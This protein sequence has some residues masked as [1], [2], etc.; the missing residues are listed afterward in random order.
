[1][2]E[3]AQG[4]GQGNPASP[5]AKTVAPRQTLRA[6]I[7]SVAV[8]IVIACGL[9]L[10]Y[11]RGEALRNAEERATSVA[12]LLEEHIT[13]TFRT[14]DFIVEQVAVLG[15]SQPIDQL[16]ASEAAWMRLT[17]LKRG[18]P[19]PGTLWIIDKDGNTSLGTLTFPVRSVS[20]KDRYYFSAHTEKRHDLVIGP[21]VTAKQR[22]AQAFHLSRRIDDADGNLAGVAAAGFDAITFTDFYR[23]LG[24]GPHSVLTVAGTD[25]RIILRQPDP[26]QWSQTALP[27]GPLL[28]AVKSGRVRGVLRTVSPLDGVERVL[29]YRVL[30]D[31]GVI[32][33]TGIALDDVLSDWWDT[34]LLT[35]AAVIMLMGLLGWL[36]A[37]TFDSLKREEELIQGLEE[38]VRART[39]EA[40]QRAEEARRANDSKTR[41]LAAASHDLRQPLQAAGMFVEALSARLS[42]SPH[43]NI[44]D[45]MR[46]SVDA[47]QALLAT[48]LDVSTLEAGHIEPSPTSFPLAPMLIALTEQLE[49]EATKRGL[50]LRVVPTHAVVISDPV[51][52]ERM[53]RN[54]LYNALRYTNQGSILLGCRRRGTHMAICVIDTGIGIPEDK[55]TTIFEDFSRL[56]VKGHGADRGLGL[57]LAVVRRMAELLDH[58]IEVK[59]RVDKGSCFSVIVPRV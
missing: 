26:E 41:F 52:L 53:L 23:N 6:L 13:R 24:L 37:M 25:G 42:D 5:L 1:M 50:R 58:G 18:M 30:N 35:I 33:S 22:D 47:T 2:T 45:K 43:Q 46:Q 4:R 17:E 12:R 48:L 54:L 11:L 44:V 55:F 36:T 16:A 9:F 14:A 3:T 7:A 32:V 15:R 10:T 57:G 51:L 39:R 31:F 8:L 59:S 28:N 19:E 38:T 56:G 21:L 34:A 29:A 27:A 49:P 40:E 20:V